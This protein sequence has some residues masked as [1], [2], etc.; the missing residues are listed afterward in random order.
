M[1][2]N[3]QL[4]VDSAGRIVVPA[5][6]RAAWGIGPGDVLAG[7]FEDGVLRLTSR[8]QQFRAAVEALQEM[9]RRDGGTLADFL[10]WRRQDSGD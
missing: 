7:E 10:E 3:L 4:K 5:K 1:V 8:D 2:P 9:G 6:V